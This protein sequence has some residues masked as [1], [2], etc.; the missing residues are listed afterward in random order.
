M[1]GFDVFVMP[2]GVVTATDAV[3]AALPARLNV[4]SA[5]LIAVAIAFWLAVML[6]LVHVIA[7]VVI[8]APCSVVNDSVN[9]PPVIEL[10]VPGRLAPNNLI[11]WIS[12]LGLIVFDEPLPL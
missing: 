8:V 1:I 6:L 4:V 10:A 7:P 11:C 9:V 5:L 2:V 12:S 3:P